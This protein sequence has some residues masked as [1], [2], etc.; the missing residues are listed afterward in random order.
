MTRRHTALAAVV[1]AF[2]IGISAFIASGLW[3]PEAEPETALEPGV[4]Y[5]HTL[6]T[7]CGLSSMSADGRHWIPETGRVGT[8]V[9]DEWASAVDGSQDV[10]V[11]IRLDPG[12]PEKIM[13]TLNGRSVAFIPDDGRSTCI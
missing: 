3:K 1:V 12:P 11:E 8:D 5:R 7:H 13:A 10:D 6:W 9:P 2:A 4:V